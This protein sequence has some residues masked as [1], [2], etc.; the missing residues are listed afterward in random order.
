MSQLLV[1][2]HTYT[3]FILGSSF[4]RVCL[5][6]VTLFAEQKKP[7]IAISFASYLLQ[8]RLFFKSTGAKIYYFLLLPFEPFIP[9]FPVSPKIAKQYYITNIFAKNELL[10][11][12]ITIIIMASARS[13]SHCKIPMQI[14]REY[15]I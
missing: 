6:Q 8:A 13:A 10:S 15:F 3:Y 7:C 11:Q 4:T 5:G 1:D 9:R 14:C 2:S 12:S